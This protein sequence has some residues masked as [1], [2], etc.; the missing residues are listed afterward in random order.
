MKIYDCFAY[1]DE[2]M[3]LDMR[4]HIL[5]EHVDYFVIVEATKTFTGLPKPLNFDI[6]KFAKFKDKIRYIVYRGDM[7][8]PDPWIN[9]AANKNAV[10]EGLFDAKDED[11]IIFSD[12]DEITN[13]KII[14]SYNPR[15]YLYASLDQLMFNYQLNNLVLDSDGASRNWQFAKLTTYK[16]LV[17]FFGTPFNLR[18]YRKRRNVS[19]RLHNL[20]RKLRRQV[21]RHGGWHFSWIMSPQR[22]L[23]KMKSISHTDMDRPEFSNIEHIRDAIR[24]GQDIWGR[25]RL[26]KIVPVSEDYLPAY[27]VNNQEKFADFL[28]YRRPKE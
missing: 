12:A 24:Q 27:V 11:W 23:E 17:G 8:N 21:I 4:F 18:N 13:P 20:V 16:H 5:H 9:E 22:I 6:N 3:L 15:R 26:M 10:M 28:I 7:R 1:Y 19:G 14:T 25:E 2:D